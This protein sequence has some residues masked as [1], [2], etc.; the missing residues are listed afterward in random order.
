[1][2]APREDLTRPP[3]TAAS[4]PRPVGSKFRVTAKPQI[5]VAVGNRRYRAAF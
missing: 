4:K 1:L 5:P 3:V 2:A